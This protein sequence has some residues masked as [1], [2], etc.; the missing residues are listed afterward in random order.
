MTFFHTVCS[1]VHSK[2]VLKALILDVTALAVVFF[3]PVIATL[4]QLPFYMIEPMRMMVVISIAHSSRINSY[5]LAFTLSLFSWAVSGHPEFNKLLVMTAELVINVYLF[6]FLLK[7]LDNAFL[8]MI[9]AIIIS[10]I[11]CYSLYLVFFS[12]MFLQ[13]ETEPSFMIAQAITTLLFSIYISVLL[14][15]DHNNFCGFVL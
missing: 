9:I 2:S 13:E 11:I 8:S 10:K 14:K 6:Y 5:L 3:I 1:R 7:R 15:K 12:M 4:F